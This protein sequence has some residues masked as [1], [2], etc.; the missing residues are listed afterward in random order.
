MFR[1]VF[2]KMKKQKMITWNYCYY[3]WQRIFPYFDHLNA[4]TFISRCCLIRLW[5]NVHNL[6]TMFPGGHFEYKAIINCWKSFSLL[7][8]VISIYSSLFL[9]FLPLITISLGFF[10]ADFR[11][12]NYFIFHK[13]IWFDWIFVCL[14]QLFFYYWSLIEVKK[15]IHSAIWSIP[16]TSIS[17][18]IFSF[19]I[20]EYQIKL[21]ECLLC[22]FEFHLFF[23]TFSICTRMQL[24]QIV[25]DEE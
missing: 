17:P 23:I 22:S 7:S 12:F 2:N 14:I 16:N 25:V 13:S 19:I 15:L 21:L 3:C 1:F 5:H 8:F 4:V 24:K 9:R 18:L 6:C 20:F 10:F 11:I